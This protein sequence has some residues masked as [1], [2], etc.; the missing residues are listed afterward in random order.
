M[1]FTVSTKPLVS[2]LNL[3]IVNSNISKFFQKSNVAQVTACGNELRVNLEASRI[4]TELRLKG[5]NDTSEGEATAIVDCSVLKTL[6]GTIETSEVTLE[7]TDTGII[8]HAGRSK[9]N[10]PKMLEDVDVDLNRPKMEGLEDFAEVS[11]TGWIY[12][13]DHQ[14]YAIALS[15]THAVYTRVYVGEDGNV[16]VGDFD[17]SIFTVSQ[18]A[19]L[20][21]TCLLAH[22]VIN[23][24]ASLPDGAKIAPNGTSYVIAVTTDGFDMYSQ[25]EP[26]YESDPG[27][28]SYN[29]DM[30]MGLMQV[31]TSGEIVVSPAGVLKLLRQASLLINGSRAVITMEVTDKEM[32]LHDQHTESRITLPD[33]PH[34]QFKLDF[35][36]SLLMPAISKYEE[37]TVKI[38]PAMAEDEVVGI[39]LHSDDLTTV[40]AGV[41]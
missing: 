30:I 36:M 1:K 3:G 6:M 34:A 7:F 35:D 25:F 39:I 23:L 22:T 11:K 5:S 17:N 29:A 24:F 40:L 16:I 28:G 13:R 27:T 18:K 9:F 14:M 19:K 21:S 31:P 10:L 33:A 37:E 12:V 26:Y 4:V 15:F 38:Y 8:V 41:E 2:A 32:I 20:Q